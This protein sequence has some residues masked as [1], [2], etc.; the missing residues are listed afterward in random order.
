MKRFLASLS[1]ISL[2]EV[3]GRHPAMAAGILMLLGVGGGAGIALLTTPAIVP[4]VSSSFN[5][6]Q[7]G[8]PTNNGLKPNAGTV[9]S[10][11]LPVSVTTG[12]PTGSFGAYLEMLIDPALGA[13]NDNLT[14]PFEL[15][16]LTQN[17]APGQPVFFTQTRNSSG[18]GTQWWEMPFINGIGDLGSA[19]GSGYGSGLYPFQGT[20]GGCA[21]E[22]GGIWFGTNIQ[23]VNP[24]FG[25][26]TT[27]TFSAATVPNSGAAQAG[28][29]ATCAASGVS[30]QMLVTTSVPV[31]PGLS[32]GQTYPLS[33]FTTTP[34]GVLNAT[35]TAT[36]VTGSGPFT[37]VGTASGTCPTA[38][39]STGTFAAGVS[40]AFN[41]PALSTSSPYTNGQLGITTKN[42]QHIC[43][44]MGEYGDDSPTPGFQFAEMS[45][46]KGN[47]LPG[48]PALVTIPNMATANFTGATN[49][50]AQS[51]SSQAL[52]V[53]AMIPYTI[54]SAAWSNAVNGFSG[55]GLVTFQVSS[56]P[57]FIQGS[58]FTASGMSPSSV[59][60]T[61]I[62]LAGTTTSAIIGNQL[63]GP[64]GVPQ[65]L[66]NPGTITT[67]TLPQ[68]VS[69]IF[70]GMQILGATPAA[71]VLPFGTFNG[72][73]TGGV[74]TYALSANQTAALSGTIFAWQA[75]Y[76]SA[77]TGGSGPGG[78]TLTVRTQATLA[79]F[80]GAC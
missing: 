60:G 24:G 48:S 33:G 1:T 30:G 75:Y 55:L 44:F 16:F 15:L 34:T 71:F 80:F 17:G 19:A 2:I 74:G 40:G 37:V 46:E 65:V 36:S 21:V 72:T 5:P 58:E 32:F 52:N 50:T 78:S 51:S 42:G 38:I 67:A 35:F 63:T 49:T 8:G 10:S 54:T 11:E 26:L 13:G 9:G 41:F 66:A 77:A 39:S 20:G 68:M 23:I 53:S 45:D 59:N 12:G 25:C 4:F 64:G 43:S 73:G 31:S 57:G 76:Y 70:P 61:Y 7:T 69:V 27:P 29:T 14:Q 6:N 56:N 28:I 22:P 79:D 62:A 18:N 3:I 47:A